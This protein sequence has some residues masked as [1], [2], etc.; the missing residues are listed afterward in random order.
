MTAK[1]ED[2]LTSSTFLKKGIALDKMLQSIIM[3][4]R[5]KV[6]DLLIGDKNALLVASRVFGY[7]ANY[8]AQIVC[9]K[10]DSSFTTTFDLTELTNKS[11][12][13]VEVVE[14]TE[15]NT[16]IIVL[17]KSDFVVEFRLLTSQDES[18]MSSKAGG[19]MRLLKLITVS[20]NEQTDPFYI[21][22]AMQSLPIL[23]VSVLKKAYG[24][25]MPD[26]DMKQNV[27]S[28]SPSRSS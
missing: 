8:E 17:P 23:D 26:V 27:D 15:R 1:E 13:E 16:F 5:I 14:R 21:E 19:S 4:K 11:S 18:K 25:V 12:T 10:C 22:R 28:I 6:K 24:R 7:G 3:D 20:I 2:I 9:P